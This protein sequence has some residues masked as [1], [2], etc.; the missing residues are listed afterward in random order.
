[1]THKWDQGRELWV[2]DPPC[3]DCAHAVS[4]DRCECGHFADEH[5][6]PYEDEGPCTACDCGGFQI[7]RNH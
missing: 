5:L 6:Y 2:A 7:E 4:P 1:M 3:E